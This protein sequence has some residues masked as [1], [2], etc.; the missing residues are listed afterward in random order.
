MAGRSA[1]ER[2]DAVYLKLGHLFWNTVSRDIGGR[3]RRLALGHLQPF[4]NASAGTEKRFMS[5][6]ERSFAS[7]CVTRVIGRRER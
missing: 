1:K 7:V 6:A 5:W 4:T 2:P 3:L